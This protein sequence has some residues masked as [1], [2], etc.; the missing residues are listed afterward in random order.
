MKQKLVRRITDVAVPILGVS[1]NDVRIFLQE[2][3]NDSF[4][5][6]GVLA[7]DNMPPEHKL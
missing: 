4:A 2:M 3:S 7:C 6:A 1:D 5:V